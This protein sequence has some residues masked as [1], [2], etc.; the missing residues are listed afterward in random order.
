[1]LFFT[2]SLSQALL[3]LRGDLVDTAQQNAKANAS[4][5]EQQLNV[6]KLIDKETK[7]LKEVLEET[8]NRLDHAR[9]DV[10]KFKGQVSGLTKEFDQVKEVNCMFFLS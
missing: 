4:E 5:Q 3:Q 7:R 9:R 6:Q 1:M 10:K 2:Q 8:Q